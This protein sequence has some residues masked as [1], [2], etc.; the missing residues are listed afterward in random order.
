MY[1]Y[2]GNEAIKETTNHTILSAGRFSI[3][4]EGK[5]APSTNFAQPLSMTLRDRSEKEVEEKTLPL[6]FPIAHSKL[7]AYRTG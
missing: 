5:N 3:G 7:S 2:S 4:G 6:I 1:N